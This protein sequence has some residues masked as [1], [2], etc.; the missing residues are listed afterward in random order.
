MPRLEEVGYYLRGLWLLLVG[1][2]EGFHYL[3]LT[4]R[5]FWRSWWAILFCLPPTLLSWASFRL[6][7]LT[8]MPQGTP[9]GPLMSTCRSPSTPSTP[10]SSTRSM[11]VSGSPSA[12][13]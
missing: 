12:S 10:V 6:Y 8:Q 13:V 5:G 11:T 1:K 4:E 9:A 3:D 2:A 7:F